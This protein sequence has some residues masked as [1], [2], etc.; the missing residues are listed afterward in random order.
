MT[1]LVSA[2]GQLWLFSLVRWL[3]RLILSFK[4]E[5]CIAGFGGKVLSNQPT[6][7]RDLYNASKNKLSVLAFQA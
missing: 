4:D 5:S 1:V 7:A 2:L 3:S 6:D